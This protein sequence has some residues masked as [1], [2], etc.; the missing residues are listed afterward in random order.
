MTLGT[1]PGS[2]NRVTSSTTLMTRVSSRHPVAEVDGIDATD[3]VEREVR[4]HI[5]MIIAS[6]PSASPLAAYRFETY[7]EQL[8]IM[9][10][11]LSRR[12]SEEDRQDTPG[13]Y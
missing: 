4:G 8:G 3:L 6:R 9:C 11:T 13:S 7:P 2:W 5:S 1:A 12:V 10:P